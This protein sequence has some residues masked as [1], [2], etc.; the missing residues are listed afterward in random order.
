MALGAGA[1]DTLRMVLFEGAKVTAAGVIV[2]LAAAFALT[3]LMSTLLYKVSAADPI[4]FVG[5]SMLV[6]CVSMLANY[7]PARKASRVDPMVAL[8]YN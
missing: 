1:T 2:G 5:I 7:I 6:V 8:R 4:T 3:R